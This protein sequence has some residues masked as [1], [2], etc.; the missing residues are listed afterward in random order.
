MIPRNPFCWH[1]HL[2]RFARTI[3][4][5]PSINPVS[6]VLALVFFRF[7]LPISSPFL[8]ANLATIC[9]NFDIPL[10]T[11]AFANSIS[12]W[13]SNTGICT[14]PLSSS[15]IYSSTSNSS[16]HTRSTTA[17]SMVLLLCS[18]YTSS[19]SCPSSSVKSNGD[20][21]PGTCGNGVTH[22]GESAASKYELGFVLHILSGYTLL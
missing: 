16:R 6:S 18:W 12:C 7:V 19:T 20:L 14:V 4:D 2:L 8:S 21:E 17:G 5:P 10:A 13:T 22:N 1:Q 11:Y 3:D 15:S 9:S